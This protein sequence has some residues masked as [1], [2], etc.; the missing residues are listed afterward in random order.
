MKGT[1]ARPRHTLALEYLP[2]H[3]AHSRKTRTKLQMPFLIP[4]IVLVMWATGV[5]FIYLGL[6]VVGCMLGSKQGIR[7]GQRDYEYSTA[8][9]ADMQFRFFS[10][11]S[12]F[13]CILR[14][15]TRC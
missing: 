15:G 11:P 14:S 13:G 8:A 3:V 1:L 12:R 6:H 2:S 4:S 9:Q 7:I 5:R 10:H